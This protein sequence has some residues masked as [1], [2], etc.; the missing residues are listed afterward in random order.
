MEIH[1][2]ELSKAFIAGVKSYHTGVRNPYEIGSIDH[3]DFSKGYN[4]QKEFLENIMLE[5]CRHGS[6][7]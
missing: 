1:L 7:A 4:F 5:N 2:R 6:K 3:I